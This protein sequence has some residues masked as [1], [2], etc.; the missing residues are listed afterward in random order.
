M[1][2]IFPLLAILLLCS[3]ARTPL[4][5]EKVGILQDAPL[6]PLVTDSC[7]PPGPKE[8]E[9][10]LSQADPWMFPGTRY[11]RG[12]AKSIE[13]ETDC[14]RFVHE[15]YRRSGLTYSY[16]STR[17]LREAP[18]FEVIPE[19]EA[20]AGDLLLFRGHVGILDEEGLV[21]SATR[22]RSK[23]Q[24]SSITRMGRENFQSFRGR[25]YALR[26]R[27]VPQTP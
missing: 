10:L 22:V 1:R 26:Y 18:E 21:I 16:R 3:C 24:P 12:S 25:R 9:L 19:N 7:R 4:Q 5:K 6:P 20:T 23:R 2:A 8:R 14:S 27:C 17:D 13:K 15:V 11:R